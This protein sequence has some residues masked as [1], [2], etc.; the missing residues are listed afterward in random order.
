[1]NNLK[2]LAVL[3]ISAFLLFS[4]AFPGKAADV[5]FHELDKEEILKMAKEQDK[6]VFLFVGNHSCSMCNAAIRNFNEDFFLN[7]TINENYITWFVSYYIPGTSIKPDLSHVQPYIADYDSCKK[8]KMPTNF[9]IMALINPDDPDED[10]TFYWGVGIRTLQEL[11]DFF[12]APPDLFAGQELVWYHDEGEAFALAEEQGKY[13]LK[14]VGTPTSPNSKMA[15]KQL[16]TEPLKQLLKDH[17]IL[18]YSSDVSEVPIRT[19]AV[20]PTT[21]P[22]ITIINPEDP[23]GILEAVWGDIAVD[24]DMLEDILKSYAVS[25][26]SIASVNNVTVSGNILHISNQTNNEQIQVFTLTGQ[27]VANI[28]KNDYAVRIDASNYPKGVLVVYS[29]SGWS[30]KIVIQ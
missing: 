19:F 5:V 25:N 7:K 2:S 4:N 3:A 28:R 23:D 18:L 12:S 26:E 13:V 14:F 1:M 29:S 27:R 16:T 21:L 24:V 17:F 9:P 20:D 8:E 10:F 15:M 22:Y 30:S 6:F 11:T